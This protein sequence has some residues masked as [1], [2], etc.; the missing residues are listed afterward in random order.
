MH[1]SRASVSFLDLLTCSFGGMLLLFFVVVTINQAL[2]L[3]EL[4][5][6]RRK[7]STA[8]RTPKFVIVVYT[9][10]SEGLFPEVPSKSPWKVKPDPGG[11]EHEWFA[12]RDFAV[13]TA[14]RNPPNGV[15][16]EF[17]PRMDS[18]RFELQVFSRG[19]RLAAGTSEDKQVWPVP[20]NLVP[21]RISS[22]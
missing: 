11:F 20:A 10:R 9:S 15:G 13:L 4:A 16:I 14:E 19:Q 5:E 7:I 3:Q 2:T 12:G 8:A 1:N 18:P 22:P 21:V 17:H 6:S